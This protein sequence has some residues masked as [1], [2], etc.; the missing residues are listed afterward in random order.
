M[1]INS[2]T[3]K[4]LLGDHLGSTSLTVS[5]TGVKIADMQYKACP[6]AG[7]PQGYSVLR[8][9]ETRSSTGDTPTDYQYTGQRNE[10]GIGL[11]YY[12]ARWYDAALGRFAQADTVIPPGV[13]GYDR[14]A[15]TNNSPLNATDPSGH[16]L[17]PG[18]VWI[19]DGTSA[20]NG[21]Y[22]LPGYT[23]PIITPPTPTPP[24][25]SP[26]VVPEPP[27]PYIPNFG[28]IDAS[29][30]ENPTCGNA[31]IGCK[32]LDKNTMLIWAN[33]TYSIINLKDLPSEAQTHL[34]LFVNNANN[35]ASAKSD[36]GLDATELGIGLTVAI[37]AL[38]ST[39]VT[40]VAGGIVTLGGVALTAL[41]GINLAN[42]ITTS[43]NA[44]AAAENEFYYFLAAINLPNVVEIGH[45]IE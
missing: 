7:I 32:L 9:G 22:Y 31:T 1:T 41:G 33:G 37:A 2:N 16:C 40:T 43:I 6:L 36:I 30:T 27:K 38:L 10:S 21:G 39:P 28:V 12:N 35:Y 4:S 42:D 24:I 8:E 19:P 17:G 26:V 15:Y 45:I 23:P 3:L 20:C 14:Y 29:K 44:K 25:T 18:N 13:Q 34:N 5:P 11:Y